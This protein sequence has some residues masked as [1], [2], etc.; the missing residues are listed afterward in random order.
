FAGNKTSIR[1]VA[2][3]FGVSESTCHAMITRVMTHLCQIAH[4]VIRYPSDL[5][6]LS[7]DFEQ[8]CFFNL[9][10]SI[11]GCVDGSY[12][13]IRWP[14]DKIRSTYI[15]RH[16]MLSITAQGICDHNRRFLDVSVGCPSKIHDGSVFK[17]SAVSKR[18]PSLCEGAWYHLLGDA[19]YPCRE[20]LLPPYKDYGNLSPQQQA[21]NTK[22]SST[23][24]LIENS[25]GILK[26]RFRQLKVLEFISVERMCQFTMSCCVIHNLCIDG[27]D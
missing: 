24:V 10:R 18:I 4:R 7:S 19:A 22:L 15:N 11:I 1:D 12:I 21:F 13:P 14:A 26:N 16:D 20:Y 5:D 8:V 23:R 27:D 3:R 25:F 6:K 17:F 9:H 2:G